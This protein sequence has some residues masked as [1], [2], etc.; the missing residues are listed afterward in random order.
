MPRNDRSCLNYQQLNQLQPAIQDQPGTSASWRS[1]RNMAQPFRSLLH[2]QPFIKSLAPIPHRRQTSPLLEIPWARELWRPGQGS[3]VSCILNLLIA[4]RL[5]SSTNP[6]WRDPFRTAEWK[7]EAPPLPEHLLPLLIFLQ[8]GR[9]E[10]IHSSRK[11]YQDKKNRWLS[12]LGKRQSNN[13]TC[14]SREEDPPHRSWVNWF[15][16]GGRQR[17]TS[18]PDSSP[19]TPSLAQLTPVQT[20]NSILVRT[21][22]LRIGDRH[23]GKSTFWIWSVQAGREAWIR[24]ISPSPLSPAFLAQ[25]ATASSLLALLLF[26]MCVSELLFLAP[27]ETRHVAHTCSWLWGP[28]ARWSWCSTS[29]CNPR[30]QW[31]SGRVKQELPGSPL[32]QMALFYLQIRSQWHFAIH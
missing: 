15:W 22:G 4:S 24:L 18:H 28:E 32:P 30:L 3:I 19:D 2:L 27:G 29:I 11:G 25:T 13:S 10:Y 6:S 26:A 7:V 17:K 23:S 5:F 16:E 8:P 14:V 12:S 1:S 9:S 31:A 21:L 20:L